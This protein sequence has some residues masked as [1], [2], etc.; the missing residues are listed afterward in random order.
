[1]AH[2]STVA[3]WIYPSPDAVGSCSPLPPAA[4]CSPYP[5]QVNSLSPENALS[6]SFNCCLSEINSSLPILCLQFTWSQK[7]FAHSGA[8]LHPLLRCSS[9][10][11][12]PSLI[13]SA[14][15]L[16]YL[17]YGTASFCTHWCLHPC[18]LLIPC[19]ALAQLPSLPPSALLRVQPV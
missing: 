15:L 8:L 18:S 9:K 5:L 13:F 10:A 3:A 2:L 1:M 19:S 14:S 16:Q 17:N 12:C 11:V 4:C 6:D 7:G